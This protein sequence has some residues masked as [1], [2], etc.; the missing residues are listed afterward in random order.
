M[1]PVAEDLA[2]YREKFRRRLPASLDELRGPT[3]GIVGYR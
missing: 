3:L 2:V 1:G